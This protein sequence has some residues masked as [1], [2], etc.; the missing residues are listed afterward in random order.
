ML[1]T[2]ADP[3]RQLPG[4]SRHTDRLIASPF[5]PPDLQQESEPRVAV[6]HMHVRPALALYQRTAMEWRERRECQSLV[7]PFQSAIVHPDQGRANVV[8]DDA[9]QHC[10]ALVDVLSLSQLH[11]SNGWF[12]GS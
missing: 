5:L 8:P 10:Q 2:L 9:S 3:A 12:A 7:L 4:S 11:R 1:I 6:G